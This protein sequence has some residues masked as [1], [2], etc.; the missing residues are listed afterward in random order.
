MTIDEFD[1]TPS[2]GRLVES[3]RDTG[4]SFVTAVADIVDNSIA[5]DS[6]KI[7]I[8]LELEF[9]GRLKLYIA[10]N[11]HGM[12]EIDVM[13]AM[14]YGSK[15]RE[16]PKSLGKFG[17]GL[18]TASTSF[19][20]SLT[21]IS[22]KDSELA[23]RCWDID[24]IIKE[25]KW[26]LLTPEIEDDDLKRLNDVSKNDGTLI[27]WDNID[28]LVRSHDGVPDRKQVD[29]FIETLKEHLSGVFY[30]FL[31][32]TEENVEININGENLCGWDP[33]CSW[34]EEDLKVA[35]ESLKILSAGKEIGSFDF[36]VY[37]L[38]NK[39]Q[40]SPEDERKA[41]YGLDNQGFHIYRENRLIYSGGWLN[42]M[43]VKEPHSNLIRVEISFNHELDEQFQIDIKKSNIILP[44]AIRKEI[45]ERLIP[46][47]READRRYRGAKKKNDKD[48]SGDIHGQSSTAIDKKMDE[49]INSQIKDINPEDG[50]GT[51]SNQFGEVTIKI[52]V[53]KE[54][55]FV[56]QAEES[57]NHG[58]LW[59]FFIGSENRHGVLLNQS[60]E[61]YRRFYFPNQNNSMLVQAMDS[62]FWALAEAEMATINNVAQ[63]NIEELRFRVSRI[64]E[65]LAEELP[66]LTEQEDL[67]D[68]E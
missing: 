38:P 25:D 43:F 14:R 64:L 51:V 26:Q 39:N 19:C 36:N 4:Y 37:I 24:E 32:S 28:R 27:I 68:N 21:V 17:M 50:T 2:P 3:L 15:K 67:V 49:N 29:H 7:N 60:H 30:R 57:L 41:R 61:F 11:G 53:H 40:M 5:A 45:K 48:K 13:N 18:K 22:R 63:R 1:I 54:A 47:R 65:G 23:S 42:R 8:N 44:Q 55:K 46:L 52:P 62:V 20:R 9:D 59:Q 16:N 31:N 6:T 34:M 35:S 56:V 12:S 33:F 10:D 66:E 58:A